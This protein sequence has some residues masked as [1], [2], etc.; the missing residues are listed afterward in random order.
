[1]DKSKITYLILILV[2]LIVTAY[3]T[4][5]F[6]IK[7]WP[8]NQNKSTSAVDLTPIA[9][10]IEKGNKDISKPDLS[11]GVVGNNE[12]P[13]NVSDGTPYDCGM[14]TM[15][16]PQGWLV[17]LQD[18]GKLAISSDLKNSTN[19]IYVSQTDTLV[20][21]SENTDKALDEIKQ[22]LGSEFTVEQV[23]KT[24][25]LG[26][27]CLTVSGSSDRNGIKAGLLA[28][29]I[30]SDASAPGY[31]IIGFF[32]PKDSSIR[33]NIVASMATMSIKTAR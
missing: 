32:D 16:F 7:F 23:D 14:Y 27:K 1:M 13:Y 8:F 10:S 6:F 26:K 3:L 19:S 20:F 22:S 21:N 12:D 2:L 31:W 9:Q 17:V 15:S 29:A 18:K 33:D 30:P 24:D 4:T 25:F 28:M 5:A 11:K